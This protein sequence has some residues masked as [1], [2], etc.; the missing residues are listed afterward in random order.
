MDSKPESVEKL[1]CERYTN[2]D[3]IL[4]HCSKLLY[5]QLAVTKT[6]K[7]ITL[8][9][10]TIEERLQQEISKIV[11]EQQELD[12]NRSRAGS[13]ANAIKSPTSDLV[14]MVEK[15][16]GA[17]TLKL[18]MYM[19]FQKYVSIELMTLIN[20]IQEIRQGPAKYLQ[21]FKG[22]SFHKEGACPICASPVKEK[23][24]DFDLD[25]ILKSITP[26]F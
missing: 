20:D 8:G 3:Q 19:E 18:Q 17:I 5:K 13:Y 23:S 14:K 10:T 12:V 22:C 21:L 6:L 15:T 16:N 25:D 1:L 9:V 4:K 26:I 24:T 2:Y 7:H 11:A